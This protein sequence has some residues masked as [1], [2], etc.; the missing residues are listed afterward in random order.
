MNN[1]VDDDDCDC[2]CGGFE[3]V[4][5]T[6]EV[7]GKVDDG[8]NEDHNGFEVVDDFSI[9]ERMGNWNFWVWGRNFGLRRDIED[10]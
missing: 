9:G 4:V 2:D 1:S 3:V 5:Y 10:N 7:K 8:E 6:M